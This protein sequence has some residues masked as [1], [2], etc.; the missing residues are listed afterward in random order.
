M[1]NLVASVLRHDAD[2][3][4]Q[5]SAS[6][7]VIYKARLSSEGETMR[8]WS[9][10]PGAERS[11]RATAEAW[12]EDRIKLAL[13]GAGAGAVVLA[14]T[15][16]GAAMLFARLARRLRDGTKARAEG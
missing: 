16:T 5:L 1:G 2:A 4:R 3:W 15:A 10:S 8:E 9:A 6:S 14:G 13:A 7:S 11:F 12:R